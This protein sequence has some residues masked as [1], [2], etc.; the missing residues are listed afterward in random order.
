MNRSLKVNE[1]NGKNLVKIMNC[2][3][4]EWGSKLKLSEQMASDDDSNGDSGCP[5]SV[6]SSDKSPS[7][8][9]VKKYPGTIFYFYWT[10]KYKNSEKTYMIQY[11]LEKC[12]FGNFINHYTFCFGSWRLWL[13]SSQRCFIILRKNMN[14]MT[15]TEV[16]VSLAC[17][18]KN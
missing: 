11:Y 7:P 3:L 8:F 5:L 13:S 1:H 6:P 12:V 4:K 10:L 2:W 9:S 17:L 15:E 18:R 14:K 16:E